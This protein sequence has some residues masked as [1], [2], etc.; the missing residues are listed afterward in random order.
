MATIAATPGLEE[1]PAIG[2]IAH[3]D[4][5][6]EMSGAGRASDRPSAITTGATSCCPTIQSAVIR[7]SDN[8]ALAAR[9][10]DDIVTASGTTLLGADDKAGV[11]AIMAAVEHLLTDPE[12][13]TARFASA[14]RPTKRSAAAPTTSMSSV[15]IAR[16]RLHAGR[17][18]PRRA[19]VRQLLG[20]PLRPSAFKGFNTHP[21]YAKGRMVNA[22]RAAADFIAS[23]PRDRT[24]HRRPPRATTVSCMR[25]TCR[26]ASIG[27][28]SRCCCGT[29]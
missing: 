2:F 3:V 6:P 23:L 4:T 25:T 5:S 11:A 10:G 18:Q 12:S 29:S 14:S 7:A 15:S 1:R 21:G 28:S 17:R 27:R 9:I 13:L 8:P 19:R 16:L 20:R 26:P 24:C 22:I